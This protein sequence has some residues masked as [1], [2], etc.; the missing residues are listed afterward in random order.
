VALIGANGVGP[1]REEIR[2]LYEEHGRGLIA[3]ACS[4]LH[5]FTAAEDVLH[6]IFERLLRGDIKLESPS[7]PYLYR[8]VRN[9]SLNYVRNRARDAE[10][11]EDWFESPAGMHEEAVV[12]QSALRDLPDEQRE[13]IVLHVWGQLSFEEIAATIG[14][15][16]K[17]AASR[18]RYGLAKLRTQFNPA[19]KG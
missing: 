2:R 7:A 9:A 11:D 13:T 12:L 8:A 19:P 14:I 3:Y 10:L 5:G 15:S 16:S 6:Q 1:D 18:Y 4:F 17:T